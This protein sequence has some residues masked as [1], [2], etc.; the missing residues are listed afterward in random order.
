[1]RRRLSTPQHEGG[2]NNNNNN[3]NV[4]A[5]VVLI[6]LALMAAISN[7]FTL[8]PHAVGDIPSAASGGSSHLLSFAERQLQQ[9]TEK[10][11]NASGS[12]AATTA[13]RERRSLLYQ[14]KPAQERSEKDIHAARNE[15]GS[16]SDSYS[17]FFQQTS[18]FR[19]SSNED[20]TIYTTFFKSLR[21]DDMKH[22]TYVELGGYNGKTESN[23]RFFDVCL[24]W[25]GLLI[26]ANPSAFPE[27]IRNRPH[28]HR[29]SFAPSCSV[30]EE[31]ANKTVGFHS[32]P[33]A[34]TNAAQVDTANSESYKDIIPVQV[35]C[36]SLT[37]VLLDHFA[38]GHV[39]FFSLDVEGAEAL[40]VQN[41]DFDQVFIEV[42]IAENV[43]AHCKINEPCESRQLTR[44][45]MKEAGYSLFE[46]LVSRSDLYVHPKS[47]FL[48]IADAIKAARTAE[49]L[50]LEPAKRVEPLLISSS[51]ATGYK[52]ALYQHEPAKQR[53]EEGIQAASME[54][55]NRDD[56]YSKYFEQGR[57][58]R[59]SS[60]EDKTI[61]TSFFQSLLP[62]DIKDM[63]YVEL[64]GYDGMTESN[65]RFFDVCLGWQGLLIEA[66]PTAYPLLVQNR[67]HA[68]RLSFAPSCSIEEEAANKTVGF[69][70]TPRAWTNAAQVDTAN[71][72]SYKEI[73]PVQVPCG[74][75]TPVLLDFFPGGHVTF[76]SLDVEGAEALVLQNIDFDQVYIEILIAENQNNHCPINGPCESRRLAREK[77]Q[78][79]GY[80]LFEKVVHRSDLYIHPKSRFLAAMNNGGMPL[81]QQTIQ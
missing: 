20:R 2:N 67:P 1:M 70:S 50:P 28:A 11:T 79:A 68:H 10:S 29:L 65:S 21:P 44:Q 66:N 13:A 30:E 72:D 36:G 6:T 81:H 39:A 60:N 54:C 34:W 12:A 27:L 35:P 41:I 37:P 56:L 40:V 3:N 42:L 78:E 45:R 73:V 69:L 76:F 16:P 17:K 38:A 74:S 14:F 47:R 55:G 15:C 48:A 51:S 22:M 46:D 49:L 52:R 75:L 31:A 19:S 80:T 57:P 25:N 24:G 53:S 26:E 5:R 43:N 63:T 64:G 23:S 4:N 58:F 59:S 61:Y 71:S 7:L 8:T 33:R 77:M 32:T 18:E 9:F 62:Q